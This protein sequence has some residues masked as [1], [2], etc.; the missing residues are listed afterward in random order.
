MNGHGL[1]PYL[2]FFMNFVALAQSLI[3]RIWVV[4]IQEDYTIEDHLTFVG[5]KVPI[6]ERIRLQPHHD[7]Y[8]IPSSNDDND[9]ISAIRSDPGVGFV[10]KVPRNYLRPIE[11]AFPYGFDEDDEEI[12]TARRSWF[13]LKEADPEVQVS[14]L[15]GQ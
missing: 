7:A 9:L 13:G 3:C 15:G 1:S 5:R 10:V 6:H 14:D 8:T 11:E 12:Y 4:G 2:F